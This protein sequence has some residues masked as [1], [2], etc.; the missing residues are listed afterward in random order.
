MTAYNLSVAS[1]AGFSFAAAASLGLR[2]SK[3]RLGVGLAAGAGTVFA[4]NLA[5]AL[6]AWNAPFAAD[7]DYW[8]ASRVIG[9]ENLK[10]INEFPFFTFFHADLH[11][12]LLA[13]PFFIAAFVVAHRWVE[14]G[15]GKGL[16]AWPSML[17]VALVA[18]TA[19]AANFWNLPAMA[20]LLVGCGV[21][22]TTRGERVPGPAGAVLGGLAGVAALFASWILFYPYTSSFQL[23]NNGLGRTT[24]FSGLIEFAGVW[25]IL[26]A[27]CAVGLWPRS[28]EDSE[29][30][31]RR[32]DLGLALAAAAAL[33]A[34]L[35]LQMPAMTVVLFLGF[36]AARAAWKSLRADG[37]DG[38]GVFAAFLVLLGLGMIGGCELV[39][40]KD[41]YG[42]DLQRMNTIFKFYHQ[43]WPL[44]AIGGVVFA[45]RA[46]AAGTRK[47]PAIR[48]VLTVCALLAALWPLNAAVSRFRQKD[49]PLSL[50]ARGPLARRSAGDA[51]AIDWMMHNAHVGSVVLEASGDPYSE[52]ARI[53]S[54]TGI[55]TVLGWANHEGLW[56]SNDPEVATR[57]A[58]IKLF[59]TTPDPR[60]A[61]NAIRRYGVTHVVVGDMERRLYGGAAAVQT[62]PFLSPVFSSGGT[63]IY[64]VARPE[65]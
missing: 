22:L 46:L 41:S 57:Q 48:A 42:A 30:A 19:R 62:F 61:W 13:F 39:Y 52:F 53:S 26:F 51:A 27:V 58:E 32:R 5:G 1:F 36:L 6:D 47:R 15:S 59:Y 28:A 4:G 12:H 54:H 23:T 7:F 64:S 10:T 56:R 60:V 29:T 34:G 17:L 37:G 43:A 20:I 63:T 44:V 24:M 11:P 49:G 25:G 3:G 38:E 50:D 65:R 55:P 2:L 40:F 31:A 16:R 9:P 14:T 35:A 33:V 45:G 18:G 8:H 21:F